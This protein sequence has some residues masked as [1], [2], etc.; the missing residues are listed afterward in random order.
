MKKKVYLRYMSNTNNQYIY[1]DASGNI[2]QW[3]NLYEEI[4]N[5]YCEH[6]LTTITENL[7]GKY[8]IDEIQEAYKFLNYWINKYHA[9]YRDDKN[10]NFDEIETEDKLYDLMKKVNTTL[11]ISLTDQCNL[12]CRYCIYSEEYEYT[13][14]KSNKYLDMSTANKIVKFYLGFI[15]EAI[16]QNPTRIYNISFY[17]G[18]PLLNLKVMLKIIDSFNKVYPRRFQYNVTTNGLGLTLDVCKELEKRH[19][20][21]LVS[22][23]GPKE[24]N[25]RLRIDLKKKGSFDRIINNL[26]IIKN[27]L[28]DYYASK[29][30][31]A[32]VYDYRTNII[33]TNQYFGEECG[34]KKLPPI[35][36]VNRVSDINTNYYSK[37]SKE[38]KKTYF[39]IV[40]N[41]VY[42]GICAEDYERVNG[43]SNIFFEQ[44]KLL[45]R[46]ENEKIPYLISV[47]LSDRVEKPLESID[48]YFFQSRG[49]IPTICEQY[50]SK[51]KLLSASEKRRKLK[52][53]LNEIDFYSRRKYN[54]C[55]FGSISVNISREI[56]PCPGI[57]KKVGK[58]CN[59]GSCCIDIE[60]RESYWKS[61]KNDTNC[62]NCGLKYMCVDC[63]A[64]NLDYSKCCKFYDYIK[65]HNVIETIGI[66]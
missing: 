35:K 41:I 60:L 52:G 56:T 14:E 24:E 50:T 59:D 55:L 12:R 25:D 47:N 54:A 27:A 36:I 44:N 2:F 16:E 26:K 46:L 58:L 7:L 49:K 4:I 42:W 53:T 57:R 31:I 30:G 33:R 5:M 43:S 65:S 48:D 66:R 21:I 15:K 9:F 45:D 11:L 13:K 29:M 20:N 51:K 19:V 17:G 61:T 37:F 62:R 3:N 22:L 18:E 39:N 64:L 8:N 63:S 40:L 6:N 1:D 23:D 28:P 34:S 38:E 32:A 10:Y